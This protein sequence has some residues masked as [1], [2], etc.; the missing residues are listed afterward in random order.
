MAKNFSRPRKLFTY[1]FQRPSR[2]PWI[3]GEMLGY[4]GTCYYVSLFNLCK[5]LM[6]N[7]LEARGV[8]PLFRHS[9]SRDVRRCPGREGSPAIGKR[10]IASDGHGCY[11]FWYHRTVLRLVSGNDQIQNTLPRASGM[12]LG[13]SVGSLLRKQ[14]GR[15]RKDSRNLDAMSFVGKVSIVRHLLAVASGSQPACLF[16]EPPRSHSCLPCGRER[17]ADGAD[18]RASTL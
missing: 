14:T 5:Y 15:G 6:M 4:R 17:R 12:K 3:L 8:E 13:G 11:H 2:F 10:W 18:L 7:N 16:P 1:R 9:L